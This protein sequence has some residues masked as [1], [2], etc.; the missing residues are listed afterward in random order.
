MQSRD[1]G[2]FKECLMSSLPIRER[3]S[4]GSVVIDSFHRETE[5]I[6]ESIARR[7]IGEEALSG[8]GGSLVERQMEFQVNAP[9][10]ARAR[11][12]IQ[13]VLPS[14]HWR[15]FS[16]HAYI[17]PNGDLY[18]GEKEGDLENG[19]G[20]MFYADEAVYS[21]KWQ[22]GK[23]NGMGRV[24]FSDGGFI[25][26]HFVNGAL[27]GIGK[28][29]S[30]TSFWEGSWHEGKMHGWGKGM[31]A[32]GG[33]I[34]DGEWKNGNPDGWGI[35][36]GVDYTYIGNWVGG[37]PHGRGKAIHLDGSIIEGIWEDGKLIINESEALL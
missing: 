30:E 33:F 3:S 21:G 13:K 7:F 10:S 19:L 8:S 28:S 31:I 23:W 12:I 36:Q 24:S 17:Y 18:V 6:V 5:E 16:L 11:Q 27:E 29:Y 9:I 1:N 14:E 25:S 20:A 26:G 37:V 34:Y 15:V 22:N 2:L 4:S 32:D 35:A